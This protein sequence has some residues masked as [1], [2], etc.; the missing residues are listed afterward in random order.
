MDLKK[1]KDGGGWWFVL[2]I[3]DLK[4]KSGLFI[5]GLFRVDLLE[6]G[7]RLGGSVGRGASN[8][9]LPRDNDDASK[10]SQKIEE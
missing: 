6:F 9:E 7:E 3:N 1:K 2:E 4:I 8:L 5:A 10:K